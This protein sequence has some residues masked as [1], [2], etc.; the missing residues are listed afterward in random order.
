MAVAKFRNKVFGSTLLAVLWAT[1]AFADALPL[2]EIQ[3]TS[4]RV[5][6]LG[7]VHFL[8]ST[9]Y[10]LSAGIEAAYASA[11]QLV[12]EIDMDDLDPVEAQTVM[13][14]MATDGPDL[15]ESAG[16]AATQRLLN[17]QK[18]PV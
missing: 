14:S 5:F 18:Q 8:R 2:W 16:S 10:P 4:N 9:D 6:L 17:W 11:D 12:M 15:R 7:S 3:G 1:G 13:R